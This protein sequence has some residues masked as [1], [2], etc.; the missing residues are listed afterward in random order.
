MKYCGIVID[1]WCFENEPVGY[2]YNLKLLCELKARP[3]R[4]RKGQNVVEQLKES[5][6]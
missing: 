5:N 2:L 1:D 6:E 3:S 4:F